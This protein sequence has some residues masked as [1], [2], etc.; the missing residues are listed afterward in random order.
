MYE[1]RGKLHGPNG[2]N[3]SVLTVWMTDFETGNTRFIT[4]YPDKR[5]IK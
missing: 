1:V 5:R 3:L 4:M 2:K